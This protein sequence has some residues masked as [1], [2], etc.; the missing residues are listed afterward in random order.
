MVSGSLDVQFAERSF[1]LEYMEQQAEGAST[2]KRALQIPNLFAAGKFHTVDP[3]LSIPV[4]WFY[5]LQEFPLIQWG[6]RGRT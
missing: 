1:R 6:A 5:L 2:L 3:V 4:P